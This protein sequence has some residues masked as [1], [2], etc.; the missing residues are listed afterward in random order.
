MRLG[1]RFDHRDTAPLRSIAEQM[2]S[3]RRAE[4]DI[5]LFEKAAESAEQ[6]E[7]LIVE[8]SSKREI[9]RMAQGFTYWGVARPAID[10]L[11]G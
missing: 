8:C 10:E 5:G 6:N 4:Q 11:N 1:L 9:E 7:P 2:K 3:E